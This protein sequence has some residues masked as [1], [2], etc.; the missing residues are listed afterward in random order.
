MIKVAMTGAGGTGKTTLMNRLCD[1]LADT[2]ASVVQ[3]MSS[4]RFVRDLYGVELCEAAGNLT[5]LYSQLH[6]RQ[7]V[8]EHSKSSFEYLLSERCGLDEVGYQRVRAQSLTD[9]VESLTADQYTQVLLDQFLVGELPIWDH[10]FFKPRHK[11][12]A[13]EADGARSTDEEYVDKVEQQ[14]HWYLKSISLGHGEYAD[15][16]HVLDPENEIAYKQMCEVL[17]L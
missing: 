7:L 10:I 15:R 13:L 2:G 17:G 14:I 6:R 3:L 9:P 1:T 5:Q 11:G 8:Q 16:V 4:T 12:Y